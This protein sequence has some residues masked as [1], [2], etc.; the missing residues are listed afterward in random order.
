ML[1]SC[2]VLELLRDEDSDSCEAG[3]YH[4]CDDMHHRLDTNMLL[5]LLLLPACCTRYLSSARAF[6]T[7]LLTPYSR[8][9][10]S[11]KQKK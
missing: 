4:P 6:R 10:L 1:A 11:S 9:A 8:H 3:V 2:V 5:L 7:T